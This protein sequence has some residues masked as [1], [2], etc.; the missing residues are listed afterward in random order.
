MENSGMSGYSSWRKSYE[1]ERRGSSSSGMELCEWCISG[2]I[3]AK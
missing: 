3:A 1:G 2:N